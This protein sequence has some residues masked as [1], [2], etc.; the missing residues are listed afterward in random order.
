[1]ILDTSAIVAIVFREPEEEEFL[2]KIG[3]A[4][5]VGIGAPTLAETAIV[6]AARLGEGSQR[7]LSLM[8]ERAG[9]VV[10]PFDSAH[11][12]LA[13]EAWLRYGRGRHPAKLNFGD[14]LAY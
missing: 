6:L 13:T 8:V 9:I 7:L 4:T 11:S 10:V 14:C 1:M 2:N 12:Q 5:V 3:A